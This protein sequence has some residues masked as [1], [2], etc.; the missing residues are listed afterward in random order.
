[1]L[2]MVFIVFFNIAHYVFQ[3]LSLFSLFV[4]VCVMI[5][6]CFFNVFHYF[7]HFFDVFSFFSLLMFF[8]ILHE[9]VG[10]HLIE[11]ELSTSKL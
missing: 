1:M 4:S 9:H 6:P 10:P 8:I 7:F 3:C 11:L 5:V 2:F